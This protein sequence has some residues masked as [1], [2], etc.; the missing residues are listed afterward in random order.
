MRPG[1][2]EERLRWIPVELG[3][4]APFDL[5]QEPL[6]RLSRRSG[7]RG[8]CCAKRHTHVSRRGTTERGS[9]RAG[10]VA[11]I[12]EHAVLQA[13][14]PFRARVPRA[15]PLDRGVVPIVRHGDR[16]QAERRDTGSPCEGLA[17]LFRKPLGE[18]VGPLGAQRMIV[19][20][21][22]VVGQPLAIR[23]T[24]H[25]EA[26]EGDDAVDLLLLRREEDVPGA[27]HVRGHD[28]GRR[29][30]GV[31]GDRRE[32]DDRRATPCRPADGPFASHIAPAAEIELD[33]VVA[34]T[35]ELRGHDT[36]NLPGAPGDENPHRA[37]TLR[38]PG[39]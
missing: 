36:P 23:R 8:V 1:A 17:H 38:A 16:P 25:L 7:C 19:V 27:E 9:G 6:R 35:G 32:M 21:R 10:D 4:A 37:R 29:P 30:G 34:G 39:L 28:L 12:H 33:D 14:L 13:R 22:Q 26:R 18:P 2:I 3:P 15:A 20:H 11:N 31:V 5:R 24:E